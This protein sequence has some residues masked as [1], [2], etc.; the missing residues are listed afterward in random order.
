MRPFECVWFICDK[1]HVC[2]NEI[3]VYEQKKKKK[4]WQQK[5][6]VLK[7]KLLE[8]KLYLRLHILYDECPAHSTQWVTYVFL[9]AQV[10]TIVITY[11]YC[12]VYTTGVG[13]GRVTDSGANSLTTIHETKHTFM[14][15]VKLHKYYI[16]T[17]CLKCSYIYIC[18][19]LKIT[20]FSSLMFESFRVW[21]S[22]SFFNV[23]PNHNNM[24]INKILF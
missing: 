5:W 17:E 18:T 9:H 24:S 8:K 14:Q 1:T 10:S 7:E 22:M 4:N 16:H 20:I 3:I 11:H 13:L 19:P 15:M 6:L 2:S 21:Y 23:Q 12:V